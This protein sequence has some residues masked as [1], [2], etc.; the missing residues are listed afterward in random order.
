MVLRFFRHFHGF[1]IFKSIE[2]QDGSRD[3]R[4]GNHFQLKS[5]HWKE[6]KVHYKIKLQQQWWWS[7]K[8]SIRTF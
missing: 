1:G 5:F 8:L 3:L 7:H 6:L 2:I 4:T